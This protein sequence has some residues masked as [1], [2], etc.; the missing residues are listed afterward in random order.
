M[1]LALKVYWPIKSRESKKMNLVNENMTEM[2]G[3]SMKDK[4]GLRRED[5]RQIQIY[6]I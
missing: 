5:K 4:D 1:F 2:I 3:V 6:Y